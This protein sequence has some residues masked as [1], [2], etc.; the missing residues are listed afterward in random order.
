M[1]KSFLLFSFL[2]SITFTYT[3]ITWDGGAG[4]SS[5]NDANNWS[6]DAVPTASDDV[7]IGML[8][9]SVSVPSGT[10]TAK[11]LEINNGADLTVA[12]GANLNV[13]TSGN[14]AP[15]DAINVNHATSI[16]TNNGT[17]T[18]EGYSTSSNDQAGVAVHSGG[19][20]NNVNTLTCQ[21]ANGYCASV[22]EGTIDNDGTINASNTRRGIS[23]LTAAVG[24]FINDGIVNITNPTNVG[25]ACIHSANNVITNNGT[26]NL[27]DFDGADI[28]VSLGDGATLENNG[29]VAFSNFTSSGRLINGLSPFN[30]NSGGNVQGA[31]TIRDDAYVD[32]GGKLTPG[33]SPGIMT[34]DG[35]ESFSNATIEMEI[36]DN[37]GVPGTDYD[38]ISMAAFTATLGGTSTL[39]VT[40]NYTPSVGHN[41]T[42]LDATTITGTFNTINVTPAHTVSFNNSTGVL[43]VDAIFPVE[44]V[45]FE[46]R[47]QGKSALLNWQTAAEVNNH[48]FEIEWSPNS[49]IWENIGFVKGAGNSYD[50]NQ[51]QFVHEN[52]SEGTNYYRLKQIDY[53]GG[54]EFSE[55]KSVEFLPK[56]VHLTIFPNPI[57]NGQLKIQVP[58]K[59]AEVIDLQLFDSA[60]RLIQKRQSFDKETVLDIQDL[61][62]GIYLLY[63][64]LNGQPFFER[65]IIH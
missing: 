65:I 5:W 10:A 62:S 58:D 22:I 14:A 40:F 18:C 8:D 54:F 24:S 29:T 9:V 50:L 16:L 59:E 60:G 28:G 26:I 2:I 63:V 13:S 7:T 11:S 31:G 30:N 39:N 51:Y 20:F 47:Q 56:N 57:K 27:N 46:A 48:G 52:L 49:H 19:T 3:Q 53:D 61:V 33:E 34:F 4:T 35:D 44:L 23:A 37:D 41:Y 55:V 43:T 1:K 36:E 25:V 42:I 38:Q 6:G 21:D 45:S 17:I 15:D 12:S 64:Q 32:M